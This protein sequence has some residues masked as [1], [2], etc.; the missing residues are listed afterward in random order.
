MN[1]MTTITKRKKIGY[2]DVR[3]A[4][5]VKETAPAHNSHVVFTY[6]D[7]LSIPEGDLNKYE[8]FEGE[9]IVSPSPYVEHEFVVANLMHALSNY[10]RKN[11]L[12]VVLGSN[13]GMYFNEINY[14]E[15]DIKFI[16]SEKLKNIHTHRIN[17]SASLVVEVVSKGSRKHD[18]GFKMHKYAQQDIEEYWIADYGKKCV[19]VYTLNKKQYELHGRFS[20]KEYLKSLLLPKI[21]ISIKN[22]FENV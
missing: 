16:S 15:P 19:E 2:S 20:G 12:G 22:V 11:K 18:Y 7:I 1:N 9:L 14:T 21:R 10:V 5:M 13:A 8:L 4:R 3:A 17:K 6:K